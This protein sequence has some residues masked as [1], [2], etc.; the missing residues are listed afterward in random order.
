MKKYVLLLLL[1]L[2]FICYC[3]IFFNLFKLFI[4]AIEESEEGYDSDFNEI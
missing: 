1:L 4:D 3:F 2:L